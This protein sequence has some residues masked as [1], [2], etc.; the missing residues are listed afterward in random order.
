MLSS[1]A[2]VSGVVLVTVLVLPTMLLLLSNHNGCRLEDTPPPGYYDPGTS[3]KNTNKDAEASRQAERRRRDEAPKV[4]TGFAR[5]QLP[6]A[7][8]QYH[9][10]VRHRCKQSVAENH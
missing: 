6:E 1:G 9:Q 3:K 2:S 10:H 4:Y 8:H 7:L 5:T